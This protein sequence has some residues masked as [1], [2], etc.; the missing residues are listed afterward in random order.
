MQ[1]YK[2]I[3]K[4]VLDKFAESDD[5]GNAN[6]TGVTRLGNVRG[7]LFEYDMSTGNFP[8]LTLRYINW[9]AVVGET[10]GFLRGYTN[11]ADFKVLG[12]PF[13]EGNAN[14]NTQW[15]AN[16]HRKGPGDLGP[17]YGSQWNNWNDMGL[18]Q[19][20]HVLTEILT[21]P[22][23]LRTLI[24]THNPEVLHT[25][26]LPPCHFAWQLVP[27]TENKVLDLHWHQRSTDVVLGLPHNI[28]SYAL[29]LELIC[30]KIGY[31]PGYLV[32]FIANIHLYENHLID[33]QKL[34]HREPSI[35]PS[36]TISGEV[37]DLTEVTPEQLHLIN[38]IPGEK[39]SFKLAV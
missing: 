31:K 36:I 35:P 37:I 27:N 22:N 8:L 34:L 39:M 25:V 23:S 29:L 26:A 9:N 13:W 10:L 4:A 24:S 19:I 6:R 1:Q 33:A 21:K 14:E 17:V 15:L 18:N 20:D 2:D 3:L 12:C 30:A 5:S 16:P 11:S 7:A 28:A 38:Y 32:G